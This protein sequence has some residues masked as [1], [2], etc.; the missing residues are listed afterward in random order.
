[1]Q[2]KFTLRQS[3][4]HSHSENKMKYKI[5]DTQLK[6]FKNLWTKFN[7]LYL[8]ASWL[9]KP[10]EPETVVRGRIHLN[11]IFVGSLKFFTI[12]RYYL[13]KMLH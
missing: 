10:R 3:I 6:T 9:G 8:V 4:M 12:C 7:N 2:S 5:T 1:M 13:I 11:G